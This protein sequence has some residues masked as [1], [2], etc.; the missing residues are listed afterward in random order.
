MR[1]A[2]ASGKHFLLPVR[3]VRRHH[4]QSV[5]G[6]VHVVP[7]ALTAGIGPRRRRRDAPRRAVPLKRPT[8]LR[9]DWFVKPNMS[10]GCTSGK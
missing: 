5:T 10:G 1:R 4:A 9:N 2:S 7:G 3:E 8:L 6:A